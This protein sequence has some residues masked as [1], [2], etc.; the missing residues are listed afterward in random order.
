MKVLLYL[1]I[2]L[3][4]LWLWRSITSAAK[5]SDA[6]KS[7]A[8]VEPAAMVQCGRCGVHLPAAEAVVGKSGSYCSQAHLQ[9]SET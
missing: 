9:Q 4:G 5:P 8:P 2:A 7:R 1:A 6:N 3:A